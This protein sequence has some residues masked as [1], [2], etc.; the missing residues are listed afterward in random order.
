[1][2]EVLSEE[3]K[4]M[5][6]VE[7]FQVGISWVGIFRGDFPG[8]NFPRTPILQTRENICFYFKIGFT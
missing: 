4:L 7:I 2:D 3:R 6:W 1:M 8:G 5:K